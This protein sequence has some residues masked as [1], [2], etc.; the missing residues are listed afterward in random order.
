MEALR[1][2]LYRLINLYGNL[3]PRTIEISQQLDILINADMKV[4]INE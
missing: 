3:D 1:E 4:V 2:K